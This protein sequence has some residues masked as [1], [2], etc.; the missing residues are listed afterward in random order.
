VPNHNRVACKIDNKRNAA[1]LQLRQAGQQASG[2]VQGSMLLQQ[3]R[4]RRHLG[5]TR[6]QVGVWQYGCLKTAGQR[7]A[8]LGL[9]RYTATRSGGSM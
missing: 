4:K 5:R 3:G 8:Q 7:I 1:A 2:V 6:D 9:F